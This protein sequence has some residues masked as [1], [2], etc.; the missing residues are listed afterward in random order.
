MTKNLFEVWLDGVSGLC[1]HNIS[2]KLASIPQEYQR[3]STERSCGILYCEPVFCFIVYGAVTWHMRLGQSSLNEFYRS[4][5]AQVT[6]RRLP[7]KR[8]L[9]AW[10]FVSQYRHQPIMQTKTFPSSKIDKS[11]TRKWSNIIARNS[12]GRMR[13]L[14]IVA[15]RQSRCVVCQRQC[16]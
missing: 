6:G 13:R 16:C 14:R 15:D 12:Y 11:C 10:S 2:W 9:I 7:K 3:A 5:G 8:A 1:Q 4:R